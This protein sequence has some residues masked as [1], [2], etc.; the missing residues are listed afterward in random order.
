MP[1]FDVIRE[2]HGELQV[3]YNEH[4]WLSY[5][6]DGDRTESAL[7]GDLHVLLPDRRSALMR[8]A[9]NMDPTMSAKVLPN[10]V[11]EWLSN[12]SLSLVDMYRAI[13]R[14][15]HTAIWIEQNCACWSDADCI[16]AVHV[17]AY[18]HRGVVLEGCKLSPVPQMFQPL[19]YCMDSRRWVLGEERRPVVAAAMRWLWAETQVRRAPVLARWQVLLCLVLA[20]DWPLPGDAM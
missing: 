6:R 5:R 18:G 8:Y 16:Y 3:H 4:G 7:H 14:N 17:R 15:D 12:P 10:Q 20:G 1:S 13:P 9:E 11:V 19:A 2:M